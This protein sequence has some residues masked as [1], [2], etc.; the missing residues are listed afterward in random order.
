MGRCW[1]GGW[2]ESWSPRGD[3]SEASGGG[4]R[5]GGDGEDDEALMICEHDVKVVSDRTDKDNID[6][7][8]LRSGLGSTEA[9]D[10]DDVARPCPAR[11]EAKQ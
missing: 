6:E 7:G 2:L 3:S 4:A 1:G 10:E 8:D 9:V 5:V 11:S